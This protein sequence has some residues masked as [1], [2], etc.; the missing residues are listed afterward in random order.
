MDKPTFRVF[1]Q[2]RMSSTRLP[3]KVLR[4][5]NGQPV[6]FWVIDRTKN[7]GLET[8]VLTSNDSSDNFIQEW[9]EK[10]EVDC[11][12]GSLNNV[13][14]RFVEAALNRPADFYIRLTADCPLIFS[15][16]I[17]QGI[18][19]CKLL[20]DQKPNSKI[21]CSN[22][23]CRSYP[24][25]LD[26]EIFS[27]NLLETTGQM[28]KD[29][30]ELEHVT[31]FMYLSPSGAEKLIQITHSTDLSNYRIT[32]DTEDD[33]SVISKIVSDKKRFLA[34]FSDFTNNL[35]NWDSIFDLNRHIHQKGIHE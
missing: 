4:N 2:A 24:R 18:K 25:G 10:N 12:R 21:Y 3:G 28:A 15:E 30:Y 9:C 5:L 8:T 1:I 32:L 16:P 19:F 31:P 22:S 20:F 6:L 29:N 23:I 11:F 14:Y 34:S 7:L 35:S 26:F 33:F 13:L 27:R 17:E